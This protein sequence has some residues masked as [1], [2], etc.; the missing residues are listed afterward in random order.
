[1]QSNLSNRIG[2]GF[3]AGL[4]AFAAA[5]ALPVAAQAQDMD[6]PV[7]DFGVKREPDAAY[8]AAEVPA[9]L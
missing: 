5:P 4:L 2:L 8:A 7:L 1:M 9:A 6:R 3:L